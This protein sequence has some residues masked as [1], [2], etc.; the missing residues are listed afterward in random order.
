MF[1]L[2]VSYVFL[3]LFFFLACA[4]GIFFALLRVLSLL[5][6]SCLVFQHDPDCRL[7]THTH[8]YIHLQ[9]L[10]LFLWG[11]I[12]RSSYPELQAGEDAQTSPAPRAAVPATLPEG[13]GPL[14]MLSDLLDSVSVLAGAS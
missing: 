14:P 6:C 2:L 3:L 13:Q 4:A 8:T 11:Y 10:E 12:S 7:D 5:M 9:N 1:L